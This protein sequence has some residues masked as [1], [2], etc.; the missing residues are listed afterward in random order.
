MQFIL[1]QQRL[2]LFHTIIDHPKAF[3]AF[4]SPQDTPDRYTTTTTTR[5]IDIFSMIMSHPALS[6]SDKSKYLETIR[7]FK[8][9]VSTYLETLESPES[10][11]DLNNIDDLC[12]SYD[13]KKTEIRALINAHKTPK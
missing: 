1:D 10:I 9:K 5:P 2:D 7:L 3:N 11:G 4:I 8:N 13:E 12:R 6:P